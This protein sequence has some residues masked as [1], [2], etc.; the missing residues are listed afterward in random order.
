MGDYCHIS[1][2][3]TFLGGSGTVTIG[4]FVNIAPGCRIVCASHD[5]L[6][7]GLSG[8]TIPDEYKGNSI[9]EDIVLSDHVLIGANS[10]VLPGVELPEGVAV[11]ALS[12]VK[13]GIYHPWSIY[14]GIPARRIGPRY[15]KDILES[16][17]RLLDEHNAGKCSSTVR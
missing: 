13:K 2:N 17:K 4:N 3:C 15:G 9:S 6:Y 5:Y 8:P 1:A 14:A 10:V 11:G 7:G 16:A 12:L